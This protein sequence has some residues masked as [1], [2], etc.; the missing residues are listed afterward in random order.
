[1]QV[2]PHPWGVTAENAGL[3]R[4]SAGVRRRDVSRCRGPSRLCPCTEE[5]S[6]HRAGDVAHVNHKSRHHPV[7]PFFARSG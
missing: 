7:A 3:P 1:V 4:R 2:R 5:M 6:H